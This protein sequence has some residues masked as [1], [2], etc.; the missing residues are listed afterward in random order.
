MNV[1][2]Q[3]KRILQ[4]HHSKL[5]SNESCETDEDIIMD[6]Q[7]GELFKNL[8]KDKKIGTNSFTFLLNVDGISLCDKSNKSIWPVILVIIQLPREIRYCL[9]NVIIAGI[10]TGSK[11]IFKHFLKPIIH[12]LSLLE[13]GCLIKLNN[14][15]YLFNFFVT[16]GVF[17]KPA[18]AAILN[19][20]SCTGFYGCL[21]CMQKGEGVKTKKG[22]FEENFICL[23]KF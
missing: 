4:K 8:M 13:Q 3:M 21:K 16:H 2:T 22:F 7:D 12:E 6:I 19:I 14:K 10:S 20:K 15:R 5:I 17:D 9:Q 18:R 23:K 1:K 11:P